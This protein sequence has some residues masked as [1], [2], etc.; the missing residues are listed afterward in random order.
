MVITRS[1]ELL[2]DD[3]RSCESDPELRGRLGSADSPSLGSGE[4]SVTVAIGRSFTYILVCPQ[5]QSAVYL[6]SCSYHPRA[7]GIYQNEQLRADGRLFA[8]QI[9]SAII[10]YLVPEPFS[11]KRFPFLKVRAGGSFASMW[12]IHGSCPS[13]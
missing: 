12:V 5:I 3:S 6:A 13:A 2:A 11:S 1:I 7:H 10:R 8:L 4:C 9:T